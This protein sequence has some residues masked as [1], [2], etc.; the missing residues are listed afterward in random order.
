EAK[1]IAEYIKNVLKATELNNGFGHCEVFLTPEPY[2]IEVNPRIA[3]AS[4]MVNRLTSACIGENQI[5]LM[6]QSINDPAGFL[7][8]C[9]EPPLPLKRYGRML[10]LQNWT[11]KVIGK[12]NMDTLKKFPSYLDSMQL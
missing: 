10:Q 6:A 12:L 11:P 3:G 1:K 7:K 4:G 2:L 5:T 8:R 9:E